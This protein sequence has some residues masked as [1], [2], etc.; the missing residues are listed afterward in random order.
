MVAFVTE[1]GVEG[2]SVLEIGGGIGDVQLELLRRGA[3]HATNLELVDT[4]DADAVA[5][6]SAAG[7]ADRVTRRQ[8]DIAIAPDAVDAHDFVILHRVVCCYADYQRLLTA[9]ADHARRALVFSYPARNLL[10]RLLF[11]AE[12]IGRRPKRN[13]FRTF[14][15]DPMAMTAAAEHGDLETSYRHRGL[16]WHIVGLTTVSEG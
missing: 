1:Q 7:L 11:G 15:H 8:L 14:L 16:G 12:N 13:P 5:L 4:Y 10:V 2:A 3:A 6:A 9:A